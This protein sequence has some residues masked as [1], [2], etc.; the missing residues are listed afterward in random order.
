MPGISK[1]GVLVP[2]TFRR[3]GCL[4]CLLESAPFEILLVTLTA[5]SSPLTLDTGRFRFVALQA[6]LFT[7]DTTIPTLALLGL[8]GSIVGD[9]S[10][11]RSILDWIFDLCVILCVALCR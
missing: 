3:F 9:T 8:V 1:A 2:S 11:R 10:R 7:G 6:L 4:G 5:Y